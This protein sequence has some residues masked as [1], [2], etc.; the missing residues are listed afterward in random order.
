MTK[1]AVKR[2]AAKTAAAKRRPAAAAPAPSAPA[3]MLE[4][5]IQALARARKQAE[6]GPAKVMASL[7]DPFGFRKLEDV[8][9]Q[10]VAG[11]LERLGWPNA[12]ALA[13]LLREVEDLRKRVARLEKPGR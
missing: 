13:E 5:G 11:A 12:A 4:S 2:P 7:I 6:S 10:R 3:S 8:F 1:P 9:D